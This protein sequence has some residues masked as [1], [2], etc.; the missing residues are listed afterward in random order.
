MKNVL[1]A[2]TC[3]GIAAAIMSPKPLVEVTFIFNKY[4]DKEEK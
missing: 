3:I 2:M 4:N 1:M